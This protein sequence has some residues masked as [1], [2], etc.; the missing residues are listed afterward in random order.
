MDP[1]EPHRVWYTVRSKGVH[2]KPLQ[3]GP[4]RFQATN[5][6]C[7]LVYLVRPAAAAGG[8]A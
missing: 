1:Y 2:V 8:K 5:K 7:T 4:Y 6:V 3:L